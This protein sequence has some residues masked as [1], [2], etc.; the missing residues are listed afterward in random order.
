[1][2][3]GRC[4]IISSKNEMTKNDLIETILLIIN[5]I[6]DYTSTLNQITPTLFDK[7]ILSQENEDDGSVSTGQSSGDDNGGKSTQNKDNEE[8]KYTLTDY[9]YFWAKK[10]QFN[11]NMLILTLM[12]IDKLLSKEFILTENNVKNVLFTSMV[13]TQKYYEDEN[14]NDKDYSKIIGI[15]T[16]EL[17]KMQIEF[18]SLVD[19]SLH[20]TDEKFAK[21]KY[22]LEDMWRK[23]LSIFSFT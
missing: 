23:N 7:S 15:N 18:L 16:N 13:L 12:N 21:Y 22:N 10:L 4:A 11:E 8:D 5:K 14:F 9:F 19:F 3:T 2:N 17:I 1:M 20:I 6:L